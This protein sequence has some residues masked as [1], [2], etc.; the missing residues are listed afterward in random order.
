MNT[1]YILSIVAALVVAPHI[2][3]A[4]EPCGFLV[5]IYED[6]RFEEPITNCDNPFDLSEPNPDITVTY[7]D[8]TIIEG[9]V[10]PIHNQLETMRI[11]GSTAFHIDSILYYKDGSDY[12]RTQNL[13]GDLGTFTFS[14]TGTYTLVIHEIL[15]PPVVGF[16]E[17]I[18]TRLL[19]TAHAYHGPSVVL[20]FEVIE[21]V[22]EIDPLLLQYEPILYLHPDEQYQPMNVEPFIE[23]SVLWNADGI[24]EDTLVTPNPIEDDLVSGNS[25]DLYLSF[26]DPENPKSFDSDG[27]REKY[28][29]LVLSGA[30]VPT[31]YAYRSTDSYTDEDGV[32][33]EYIVLQYWYFYAFNDWKEHGG[34][35]NHEGDWESVFVFLDADTEEPK[36]VAYSSHFNDGDPELFNVSQ[37]NSVRRIWSE[38][39]TDGDQLLSY[40]AVGSHANYPNNGINGVH[41]IPFSSDDNTSSNGIKLSSLSW[42]NKLEIRVNN[43]PLWF[44]YKGKWGSDRL[45][46]GEDG[47]QGPNYI[48][49]SGV[50]RFHKPIEWAG[51]DNISTKEI[52]EPINVVTFL[53]QIITMV[54]DSFLSAG[55]EI[56]V[57][58]HDEFINF[59]DN[60]LE[61]V[62]LPHFWDFESNLENET[63]EVEVSFSYDEDEITALDIIEEELSVL[64]YNEETDTWEAVPSIL[65]QEDNSISFVTTHFSRYALGTI[66]AEETVEDIYDRLHDNVEVLTLRKHEKRLLHKTLNLAERMDSRGRKIVE[67]LALRVFEK[68]IEWY[69]RRGK[70]ENH[71]ELLELVD[72]LVQIIKE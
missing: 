23:H 51:I 58:P 11:N 3:L 15:E 56:T 52:S 43:E 60:P 55:T 22:E 47:P 2:L 46:I 14:E 45:L 30:A 57:D 25:E 40:I 20:T 65:D 63:F 66:Q 71:Q 70:I 39:E 16:V 12:I 69:A 26:S 5:D 19:P 48:D 35:N 53:D 10:Y 41:S 24:S 59:G 17:R 29:G 54:F 50:E 72:R 31:Y 4:Q 68:K 61:A 8:T 67:L 13:L 21:A 37:Y 9:G 44:Q 1:K 36:Y 18:L 7:G 34:F 42:D 32:V 64:F 28:E 6:E 38:S 49:V 27:A 33:H 62:F